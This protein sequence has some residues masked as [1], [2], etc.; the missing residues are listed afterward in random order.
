MKRVELISPFQ[1][2]RGLS[3]EICIKASTQIYFS[4]LLRLL[5]ERYLRDLPLLQGSAWRNLRRAQYPAQSLLG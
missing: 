4:N 2:C 3:V 5:E 1:C